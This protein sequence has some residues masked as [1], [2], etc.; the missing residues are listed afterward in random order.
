MLLLCSQLNNLR[1]H[2]SVS[3]SMPLFRG[4]YITGDTIV[5]ALKS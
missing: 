5:T 2:W 1:K 4:A 3:S